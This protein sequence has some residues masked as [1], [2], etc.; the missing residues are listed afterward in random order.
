[1]KSRWGLI[2]VMLLC[3]VGCGKGAPDLSGRWNM[4]MGATNMQVEFLD[5]GQYTGSIN[6]M[7]A[8]GQVSGT[9]SVKGNILEMDAPTITG[10]GGASSPSG[11]KMKVKMVPQ[12]PDM[13]LLDAGKDKFTLT[14]MGPPK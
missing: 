8:V 9:Y 14:R 5:G 11:G 2:A 12:G 6:S 13:I 4:A 7:G 10:P 1:M 3:V